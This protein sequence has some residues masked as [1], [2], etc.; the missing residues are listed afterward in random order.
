LV[1]FSSFLIAVIFEDL[2]NTDLKEK[3]ATRLDYSFHKIKIEIIK[4]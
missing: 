2:N 1:W 3:M 4:K